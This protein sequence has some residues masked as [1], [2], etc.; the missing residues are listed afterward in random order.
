MRWANLLAIYLTVGAGVA[1]AQVVKVDEKSNSIEIRGGLRRLPFQFSVLAE[2]KPKTL[3]EVSERIYRSLPRE[4]LDL[5][6]AYIGYKRV[7]KSYEARIDFEND[8]YAVEILHK[9]WKDWGFLDGPDPLKYSVDCVGEHAVPM[10]VIL[11]I[12][13]MYI[14]DQARSGDRPN[15]NQV[16]GF[17][18]AQLASRRLFEMCE[19]AARTN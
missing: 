4:H 2:D 17:R 7:K 3:L 9:A 8:L 18:Q 6:A 1:Y 11:Q 12:G 14:N 16:E 13:F 10:W 5:I 15:F 19:R